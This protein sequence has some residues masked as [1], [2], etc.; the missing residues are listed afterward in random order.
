MARIGFR[1]IEVPEGV[2]VKETD[3]LIEVKGPKGELS[4]QL[5]DGISIDISDDEIIVKRES[6]SKHDRSMHGLYRT[7]VL[8]MIE[9]VSKGYE[10]KLEIVGTG[11]RAEK[12]G[13]TL[14]LNL[15]YS[16]KI[17]VQD[18]EGV[19]VEVPSNT[20]IIVRGF[21]K[22]KVGQHAAQIRSF[23]KPEPYKGKGVRYADEQ[24]RRKVGKT[25]A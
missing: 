2:E 16:H 15:G 14:V 17:E 24:I 6:D 1:P 13:N 21:D 20:E 25:G 22:Q 10:K 18:P 9:G 8:N 11:Y 19:E 4:Q 12:N 3:G 23:R 7:L 5:V